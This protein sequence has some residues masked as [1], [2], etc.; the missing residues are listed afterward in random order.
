M[1]MKPL[2]LIVIILIQ[3]TLVAQN[4]K[5]FGMVV[6]AGSNTPMPYANVVMIPFNDSTAM[7]GVLTDDKGFFLFEDLDRGHY[8]L[9]ISFIGYQSIVLNNVNVEQR[10][11]DLGKYAMEI[12]SENL[13]E[14]AVK[15]SKPPIAFKVDRLVVDAGSFPNA[16]VAIDLLDNIPSV[17]VD[18]DGKI[19]Y[20]G[21]GVFKVFI[22]GQSVAN[23][24][25][26]LRQIP[27]DKIE[28]IEVITNPGAKYDAEGTAGIIQVVLKRNRLEGYLIAINAK[29]ST[30]RSYDWNFSIEKNDETRGWYLNGYL[31]NQIYGKTIDE[32]QMITSA[33]LQYNIQSNARQ[34]K[35][36]TMANIEFGFNY[37]LTQNDVVDFSIY[38]DPL[39]RRDKNRTNG[40]YTETISPSGGS[41]FIDQYHLSGINTLEYQALGSTF[42]YTHDFDGELTNELTYAF[43]FSTSINPTREVMMDT[44]QNKH[45]VERFGY[46]GREE[47][48]YALETEILYEAGITDNLSLEAGVNLDLNKI[49]LIASANGS[50][51]D[52]GVLEPF[53]QEPLNQKVVFKQNI[54]ASY[55]SVKHK[56]S[57]FECQIGVRVEKTDRVSNYSFNNPSLERERIY[58][59]KKFWDFFPSLHTMFNFSE[60]S[61]LTFSY[62]RRISRANYWSLIPFTQYSTPY[63]YY[64]GNGNLLPMYSD[65]VELNFRKTWGTDYLATEVFSHYT[66]NLIQHYSRSDNEKRVVTTPEN[67][68]NS[69]STGGSVM[70]GVTVFKQWKTILALSLYS[71]S[72]KTT[73]DNLNDHETQFVSSTRLQN[74]VQ[75]PNAFSLKLDLNYNSPSISSQNRTDG[76]FYSDFSLKKG[77][78]DNAWALTLVVSDVFNTKEYGNRLST[79]GIDIHSNFD[80]TRYLSVKLSYI[81]NN[82]K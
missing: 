24:V 52:I 20:R 68:G 79:E 16:D 76:Y 42:T 40:T 36:N 73:I 12:Q 21:D 4:C 34:T 65:A 72:L 17:R 54:Y 51:D 74:I 66:N 78:K 46:E 60:S 37:D 70:A 28:R 55:V 27:V 69:W 6:D 57:K 48:E 29:A 56:I 58:A 8:K 63:S 19:T 1:Y 49:P 41:S 71:Y 13:G 30:M 81:F 43:D 2:L 53:E 11:N 62:S 15:G 75:L 31:K 61:Q 38:V 82:K 45:G 59:E 50:F 32:Q 67:V 23:G 25:D 5:L 39:K 64:K 47:D 33:D 10:H 3:T 35:D 26:K 22:N 80:M 9:K 18:L 44:K 14:I 77:F 7:R